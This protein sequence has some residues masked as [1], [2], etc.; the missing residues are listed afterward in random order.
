[1]KVR[2]KLVVSFIR[3]LC[4]GLLVLSITSCQ[5]NTIGLEFTL[6][7]DGSAYSVKASNLSFQTKMSIPET[8]KGKP[9]TVIEKAAFHRLNKKLTRLKEIE[10]PRSITTIGESAFNGSALT[11]VTIPNSVTSIG[12]LSF[13]ECSSLET[14]YY[15]GSEG[16]WHDVFIDAGNE[17]LTNATIIYNY[18][19]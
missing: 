7:E 19:D 4:F 18:K 2:K 12:E 17:K 11:N 5:K 1:M 9:V 8:Y 6:L 15:T 10:I 3:V 16:Q 14:V 13:G